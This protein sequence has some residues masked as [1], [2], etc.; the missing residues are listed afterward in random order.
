MK[1]LLYTQGGY[2]PQ[3]KN[4][5][6]RWLPKKFTSSWRVKIWGILTLTHT[7][8]QTVVKG[9]PEDLL[10]YANITCHGAQSGV[11]FV[12]LLLQPPDYK[13]RPPPWSITSYWSGIPDVYL[14]QGLEH[15][16]LRLSIWNDWQ[17][18]FHK[19]P[20]CFSAD[21]APFTLCHWFSRQSYFKD[22]GS[23]R[24]VSS[25]FSVLGI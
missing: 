11:A 1:G 20:Q 4:L 22:Q 5:W 25:D 6:P 3:V 19:T 14:A 8:K 15:I 24:I 13:H 16:R 12:I 10:M 9:K 17:L 2:D 18:Q 21:S 7:S 23:E